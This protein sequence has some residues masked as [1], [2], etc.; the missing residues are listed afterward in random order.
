VCTDAGW[1]EGGG[2]LSL[3]YLLRTSYAFE[4][5]AGWGAKGIRMDEISAGSRGDEREM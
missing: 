4:R 5:G 2:S 3:R 1:N